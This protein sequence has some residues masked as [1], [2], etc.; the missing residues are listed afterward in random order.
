MFRFLARRKLGMSQGSVQDRAW[1]NPRVFHA[2]CQLICYS[3]CCYLKLA[4]LQLAIVCVYV[5]V[6]HA[7]QICCLIYGG[8]LQYYCVALMHVL[9]PFNAGFESWVHNETISHSGIDC[10]QSTE[11]NTNPPS[12][13][14][15]QKSK[16]TVTWSQNAGLKSGC[17]TNYYRFFGVCIWFQV[18]RF[19]CSIFRSFSLATLKLLIPNCETYGPRK[20]CVFTVNSIFLTTPTWNGTF[21]LNNLFCSNSSCS[22]ASPLRYCPLPLW[23]ARLRVMVQMAFDELPPE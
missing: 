8:F 7:S 23:R 15:L 11:C 3:A 21:S 13:H 19:Q 4:R 17:E 6:L 22:Q 10:F 9:N 1:T 14:V 16:Q 2:L 20:N 18:F 5:C 12:W